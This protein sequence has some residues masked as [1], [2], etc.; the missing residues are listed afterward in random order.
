MI[1]RPLQAF[2]EA[3]GARTFSPAG[4]HDA[5]SFS[6]FFWAQELSTAATLILVTLVGSAGGALAFGLTRTR[7]RARPEPVPST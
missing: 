5:A 1:G 2:F 7:P 4:V 6:A 3:A